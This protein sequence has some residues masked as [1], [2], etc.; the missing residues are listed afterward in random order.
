MLK[1]LFAVALL[2]SLPLGAGSFAAP[3]IPE[4]FLEGL[5]ST[6]ASEIRIAFSADGS[7]MSWGSTNR[8]GG[9]GGWDIWESVR[10][11]D[12][13]GAPRPA[14]FNS[15]QND[16]DPHFSPD[17][18]GV[19]FFSNRP[20]GLGG[21]DIWFAPFDPDSKEYGPAWN[22]GPEVNS[23]GDEWAP[24]VS[25]D[26]D[27]LLFASDGRGGKGLHDLFSCERINGRWLSARP[28]EGEINSAAEDF[29]A[30]FLHDGKT[31]VFTRR[32]RDQDGADLYVSME[33][34]GRYEQARRLGANVNAAD[35]WN[36]GP[37]IHPREPGWL[38]FTA[39]RPE[40]SAGR[41]DIYRVA[42]TLAK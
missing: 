21:D 36:L 35:G 16:F 13:W 1:T 26:G 24:V 10:E 2:V 19:Y 22:L 41:S 30:A 40:R 33:R 27:R 18:K 39:H 12:C 38:Y 31:L 32:T 9:P 6:A 4:L 37:A 17:G 15:A 23:A 14:A 5:V 11:N 20:G 25:P 7:R 42:Y 34:D 28:L 29:D 8:D 3:R